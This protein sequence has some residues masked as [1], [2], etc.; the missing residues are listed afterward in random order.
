MEYAGHCKG[1]PFTDRPCVPGEG[2]KHAKV[3]FVG[4]NPGSYEAEEGRPF[5]GPSGRL[6]NATL[7]EAGL[8][9]NEVWV[10]NAVLCQHVDEYGDDTDPPKEAFVACR[11]RLI[12]E[13]N[14]IDP[15]VV[16]ALGGDAAKVIIQ[17]DRNITDLHGAMMPVADLGRYVIPTYHPAY[18][19]RGA[20]GAFD[21]M[22]SVITRARRIVQGQLSL[23]DP[24]E[25]YDIQYLTDYEEA[26]EMIAELI[27]RGPETLA[28]DTETRWL[29]DP[30]YVI[31]M[32]QISDGQTSWVFE[33]NVIDDGPN[34]DLFR[35][36]LMMPTKKWIF[37]NSEF[38]FRQLWRH[39]EAKPPNYEDTLAL[40]LC[41]T[42]RGDQVG[43]KRLSRE[44]LNSQDYEDELHSY[45]TGKKTPMDK[46][47]RPVLVK[48]A[49]MDTIF[50]HRLYPVLTQ[51]VEEEGNRQLYDRILRPVMRTF[52]DMTYHGTRINLDYVQ[53]LRDEF[54]PQLE[55]LRTDLQAYASL[56]GFSAGKV[57]KKDGPL[58]PGSPKQLIYFF[59]E[60]LGI[61]TN[62]TDIEFL[63]EH[64]HHEFVQQLME[65]RTI[66]KM[67][68]TYVEGIAD[69]VW[70]DGRVHPDFVL[71]GARTGRL[72]I[73]DPPLQTLPREGTLEGRNFRSIKKLFIPADGYTFVHADFSQLEFR[74]IWHITGD[75]RLG[76]A[77]MSGDMHRV[78][79]SEVFKKPMDEVT[80]E[81][82]NQS[83]FVSFGI[84]YGRT[85][86]TIARDEMNCPEEEAQQYIDNFFEGFPVYAKWWEDIREEVIDKGVLTTEF[87]RKRRWNL[88][89]PDQINHI[90]NQGCN[91]PPQSTA[92]DITLLA[93]IRLNEELQ[94][95]DWG[96]PLF[97]V[98]DSIEF[99]I[100]N[101]VVDDACVLIKDIME[102]PFR[103]WKE[104]CA[105]FEVKIETGPS[106]GDL[107]KWKPK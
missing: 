97:P 95:R 24:N 79:A 4:R 64:A 104:S 70:P 38:D 84:A 100:R 33:A 5:I 88:I 56:K 12:A 7:E 80:E 26:G 20:I 45:V 28:I 93:L 13:L 52:A 27:M 58:N 102:H 101:E 85:A 42:E 29:K 51:L 72:A 41:L 77:L 87:G 65:Y 61:R 30:E 9:R 8:H 103:G 63:E 31:L 55:A 50:T 17:T 73:K 78:V 43:L 19:L 98:H 89:L 14:R 106:M 69:D 53:E 49:G 40:G 99:E 66:E 105:T 91:F 74:T 68:S 37:H 107:K 2:D 75:E 62:T 94:R 54:Y 3:A 71:F 23:P 48:Y 39:W 6:L 15:T 67:L 44:W 21:D 16:V 96:M 22:L 11:P 83:K 81:D 46:A 59:N 57:V 18:I 82:R 34:Y 90:K 92:N 36:L 60:H 1:C 25:K 10:T 86:Y 47:P 35:G 32:V 76:F